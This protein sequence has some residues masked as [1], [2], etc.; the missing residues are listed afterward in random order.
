MYFTIYDDKIYFINILDWKTI[1]QLEHTCKIEVKF[2]DL[3]NI[4]KFIESAI[5]KNTKEV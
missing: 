5:I 3:V 1:Y 4:H 2:I